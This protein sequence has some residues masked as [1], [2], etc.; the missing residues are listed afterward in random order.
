MVI[1]PLTYQRMLC[2]TLPLGVYLACAVRI[3]HTI[4]THSLAAPPPTT[5]RPVRQRRSAQLLHLR[6][7]CAIGISLAFL[8]WM[9]VLQ[10]V[11]LVWLSN[12]MAGERAA[13]AASAASAA[14]PARRYLSMVLRTGRVT[15][16][17]AHCTVWKYVMVACMATLMGCTE[18]KRGQQSANA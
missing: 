7:C 8:V 16:L 6:C 18:R 5:A 11:E 4:G 14:A 12:L 3:S 9:V 17:E 10:T 15:G 2:E 13:A 1:S